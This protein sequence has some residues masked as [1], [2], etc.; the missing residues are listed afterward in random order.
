MTRAKSF[1]FWW[2]L[3]LF[4]ALLAALPVG[5][6]TASGQ[7]LP[8]NTASTGF[9]FLKPASPLGFERLTQKRTAGACVVA[10]GGTTVAKGG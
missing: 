1:L 5:P 2:P 3:L 10:K 6:K 7:N 9:D 8:Q 4:W